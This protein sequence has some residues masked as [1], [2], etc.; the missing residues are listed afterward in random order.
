[1]NGREALPRRRLQRPQPAVEH[2]RHGQRLVGRDLAGGH[3]GDGRVRCRENVGGARALRQVE[4]DRPAARARHQ[5]VDDEA[6]RHGVAGKRLV[7][8]DAGRGEI[9]AVGQRCAQDRRAIARAGL[10]AGRISRLTGYE[11][12]VAVS[13]RDVLGVV[14]D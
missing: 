8:D 10:L 3:R 14:H 5:A 1:M 9:L 11:P 13:C 2:A 12:P 6:R 4:L 7:D